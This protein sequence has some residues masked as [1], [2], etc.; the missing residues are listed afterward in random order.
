MAPD[1]QLAH[2]S[3]ALPGALLG[4]LGW[5]GWWF[6]YETPE[7]M[8]I[9]GFLGG[10]LTAG[11]AGLSAGVLLDTMGAP[12]GVTFFVAGLCARHAEAAIALLWS[13][14]NT[15]IKGFIKGVTKND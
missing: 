12:S 13:V 15:V 8:N 9:P 2:V 4:L 7:R 1:D 14:T 3:A 11:F 6:R 10:F 5:I